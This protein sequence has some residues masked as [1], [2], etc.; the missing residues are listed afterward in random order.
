ME[1]SEYLQHLAQ[2]QWLIPFFP[3]VAAAIQSLLKRPGRK[4]SASADD[5]RDGPL[6]CFCAAG[7]LR[8]D[9]AAA[10]ITTG[11]SGRSS[12]S[13]GSDSGTTHLDIG[14][15]LDP[16]TAGMAA[17]VAFVGFWIFVERH[18]LHGRR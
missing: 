10:A 13:P 17:M 14:F 15:V 5:H 3:L 9:R 11:S 1:H 7:V 18:G 8:D 16:L 12:I 4:S 6:L 2:Q